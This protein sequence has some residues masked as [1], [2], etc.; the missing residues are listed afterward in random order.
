MLSSITGG[1][2]V[3]DR[4]RRVRADFLANRERILRTAAQLFGER[5]VDLPLDEIA[6]AA[7]VG[8]ATLHR[9]FSGRV[10][11]VHSVLDAEAGRLATRAVELSSHGHPEQAL[12]VW[13]LELV[14]FSTSFRGL[15]VLLAANDADTTLE[16]R[17]H[18]LTDACRLLLT[19]AQ[20]AK[21][22]RATIDA[23]DLLKLAHGIAVASAG[24]PDVAGRLLDIVTDGLRVPPTTR[25]GH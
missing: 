21:R 20:A 1:N 17:H 6:V 8:S 22:I 5:G 16:N 23:S 7:G 25:S 9:H 13:L 18:A 15:A 19:S 4:Q 3:K 11:L 14:Q 10:E 2:L 24:S 12:R